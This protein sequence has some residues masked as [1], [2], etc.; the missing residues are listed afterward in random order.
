LAVIV[1]FH[2]NVAHLTRC[3]GAIRGALDGSTLIAD[4]IVVADGAA[5]DCSALVN[6]ITGTLL[7]VPGP[8][9]PAVA[10]NRGAAAA[11]GS[12]LLF[13]DADVAIEPAALRQLVAVFRAEPDVAA[14]FGAYDEEP[15]DRAFVSQ[16]RNLAHSFVH[17]RSR[18]D[19]RTFW[20][21][22]GAVRAEAFACVGGF[23]ERFTRPSVEDIDLGY[24]LRD[25]GYQIVLDHTIRGKHLKQWSFWSALRTDLFDRGI[26]WTQLLCRYSAM[27]DDLNVSRAYRACVMVSYAALI[28]AVGAF[29]RPV[30]LWPAVACL[31][32]LVA[33]DW[34]YY[35]FFARRR[36]LLFT[37]RW[38]PLHVLHHLSNGLSFVTG[39]CLFVLS[40]K[41]GARWPGALPADRWRG[42]TVA[43]R[44]MSV[45]PQ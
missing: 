35:L 2:R 36:G 45:R 4:L 16:A 9:G 32:A 1:P 13:I 10:R 8:S 20:A 31:L 29:W 11:H 42:R 25:A 12:L 28:F 24:R 26:P 15:D 30:L 14:V 33:L 19:A 41:V 39:T 18:R 40:R 23:D 44:V 3:L 17:Q 7:S 21:G 37:A 22:L 38:Y 5:D 34:P 27:Q 6:Q 43:A